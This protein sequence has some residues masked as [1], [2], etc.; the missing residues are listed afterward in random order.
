MS[1]KDDIEKVFRCKECNLVPLI[2]YYL[3]ESDDTIEQEVS[4]KCRNN[5]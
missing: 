4:I 1:L 2:N 3:G 5:H